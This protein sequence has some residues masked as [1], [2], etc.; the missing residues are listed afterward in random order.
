[1]SKPLTSF[2]RGRSK[3][4]PFLLAFLLLSVLVVA[5]VGSVFASDS[6]LVAQSFD[7]AEMGGAGIN[8]TLPDVNNLNFTVVY[9]AALIQ[10]IVSGSTSDVEVRATIG[11]VNVSDTE[12]ADPIDLSQ[13]V[14]TTFNA[15]GWKCTYIAQTIGW[16][17]YSVANVTSFNFYLNRTDPEFMY[18]NVTGDFQSVFA[19]AGHMSNYRFKNVTLTGSFDGV[20][21]ASVAAVSVRVYGSMS[22]YM[23]WTF[24]E[25]LPIIVVIACL[26]AV[27]VGR[28]RK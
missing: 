16:G 26:G 27:G 3:T 23:S 28:R 11:M 4:A 8:F 17:L 18:Y 20:P 13:Y 5:G 9:P 2:E 25:I 15:T 21:F 24:G 10:E 19:A 1:M 12:G 22:E 14:L 7:P 6:V